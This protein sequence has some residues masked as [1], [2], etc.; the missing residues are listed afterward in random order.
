MKPVAPEKYI[1]SWYDLGSLSNLGAEHLPDSVIGNICLIVGE[2]RDWY[3]PVQDTVGV[4]TI[5]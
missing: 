4:A 3:I 2:R 5:K 1:V